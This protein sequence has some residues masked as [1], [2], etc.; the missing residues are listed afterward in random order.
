MAVLLIQLPPE[1]V[2]N[3]LSFVDPDTLPVLQKTCRYF[4]TFVKGNSALC[5]E[6]YCHT[7][8][9]PPSYD[10]DWER[11]LQDV[12]RLRRI[13]ARKGTEKVSPSVCQAVVACVQLPFVFN[14]ATRLLKNA[15]RGGTRQARSVT[16]PQ[17]RNASLL[18]ELFESD[19]NREAFLSRSFL[20]ERAR[21]RTN[22]IQNPP[23]E[24]HQQ[25]AKLHSLFG[26]PLLK[27][28]RTRSSRMYPFACSKVYDLREYTENTRWG[29]F[30]ND[31]SDRIDWEK[32]E[33]ILLVLR[34]NMKNKGL[35]T[36]P[37]FSNFWNTAFG[38]SWPRSYIPW[39]E[40]QE[41]S[42]LELQ[43]LYNVSGTWLRVVCFLDYNDF[44]SYNFPIGDH[45]PDNIPRPALNTGEATRLILM[46][47]HVTKV[48]APGES[49]GQDHPVV[50]FEGFSRSLDGSWDENANSDLRGTARMTPEG[51]VRWTTYSIFSGIERWKSEGIQLGGIQSARGVVGN[52]FDKDLDPHGPCGPT[53][54]WKISD[55]EPNSDDQQVLLHDFLPIG[56]P[57]LSRRFF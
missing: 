23:Q 52:W 57:L 4:Y 46:K 25:S 55:L 29:P 44:F 15:S 41:R 22:G 36:F 14:T 31:G 28:G 34:N 30:M 6:I 32:V 39:P 11:E 9:E 45:L 7:L 47:I 49:D 43:D 54:F 42:E 48:E 2:H 13:C 10:L 40:E 33:A 53:A 16:Y 21:G 51:E 38:G 18:T 8:D 56:E 37:I 35:D 27:L 19:E 3:I 24:D 26:M 20:F 5:R 17:S 1:I 12:L 50:H